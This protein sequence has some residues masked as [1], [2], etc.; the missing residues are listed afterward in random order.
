MHFRDF[1]KSGHPG[2]LFTSLL[3]FDFCFAVWVLNGAM[4]PFISQ[5]F[6]LSDVQ[7]GLMVSV[8]VVA[9]ALMRF[10]LGLLS[11]YIGRKRAAQLEMGLIVIG[12][13]AGYAIVRSYEGVIAM[14]VILGIAGASFGVALSLG[15]GWYPP[16]HKGL[17]M[18]IAGAGN[19]GAVLAVLFAPPLAS[20][21]GWQA[22]YGL[23]ALPM[24]AAMILLQIFAKEPPDREQKKLSDYLRVLVDRDAWIF[25]LLYMLTFGGYIGLTSFLPTLFHD[26]YGIAKENVGRYAAGII[27]MASI[28]RIVGG[29]M[30]DRFGGLRVLFAL[31]AVIV[32]TVCAAATIPANPWMMVAIL[33]VCFSAM[34]AG[35]GAVFQL[36]PLRFKSMTPVAGSLVGEV[37]AL[38][39]GFLPVAMGI[40]MQSTGSFS[41]GFL[42]G[43][44]LAVVVL[45]ALT[46]VT[47]QWTTTWVGAGGRALS[48]TDS[49]AMTS[50]APHADFISALEGSSVIGATTNH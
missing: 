10:P 49:K 11:Q 41:L 16:E 6:G 44:G 30:A 23:A 22:V 35:N 14:G 46:R 1:L 43:A 26:Q 50:T 17:A 13:L 39:G 48:V 25:N 4:A 7:K 5:E 29:W 15:S 45:L 3:Y 20:A 21:Y 18:G 33:V 31:S 8:P 38:G 24:V 12:L 47:R 32:A 37:G 19:S 9:G 28:L 27:V 34:G 42:S 2:T 40:S 36:V